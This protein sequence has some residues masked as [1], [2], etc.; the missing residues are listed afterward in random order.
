[1]NALIPAMGK[2]CSTGCPDFKISQSQEHTNFVNVVTITFIKV[3]KK[4]I[5][6]WDALF[7]VLV[8]ISIKIKFK[9]S[10]H[11]V[12]VLMV[13]PVLLVLHIL[14]VFLLC[15]VYWLTNFTNFTVLT[16][17]DDFTRFY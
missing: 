2:S 5:V 3:L 15:L 4:M 16:F 6:L 8:R 9:I 11:V 7:L 1:M 13:V 12:H 14:L 17:Y 10:L